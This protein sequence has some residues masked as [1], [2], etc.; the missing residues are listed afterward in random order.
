MEEKEERWDFKRDA[1]IFSYLRLG[2]MKRLIYKGLIKE[3][4][5]IWHPGLSG[6]R[7]AGDQEELRPFFDEIKKR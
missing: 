7:K 2:E 5:L 4:D 6:W 1:K 3:D